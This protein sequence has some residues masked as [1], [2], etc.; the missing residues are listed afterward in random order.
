MAP[1]KKIG[2]NIDFRVLKEFGVFLVG[3]EASRGA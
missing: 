1:P 3:L 2:K